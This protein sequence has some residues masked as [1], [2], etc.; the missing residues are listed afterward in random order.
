MDAK[1]PGGASGTG[2]PSGPSRRA[3]LRGRRPP[4][5]RG[6][7]FLARVRAPAP[8][9]SRG[10][11]GSR[12]A[13]PATGGSQ[14]SDG[15][16]QNYSKNDGCQINKGKRRLRQ[17]ITRRLQIPGDERRGRRQR[18]VTLAESNNG[19]RG[20]RVCWAP[21]VNTIFYF[22]IYPLSSDAHRIFAFA[23]SFPCMRGAR[24]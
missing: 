8:C 19:A 2:S 23:L 5:G 16:L 10:W 1:A 7:P 3:A 20:T 4:P 12:G 18:A 15:T 11:R 22:L 9:A 24:F 21:T 14:G 17:R 6:D 13:R